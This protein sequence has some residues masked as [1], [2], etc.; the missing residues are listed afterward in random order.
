MDWMDV[1]RE[2][3]L[4]TEFGKSLKKQDLNDL[5]IVLGDKEMFKDKFLKLKGNVNIILQQ[6]KEDSEMF[7]NTEKISQEETEDYIKLL[8]KRREKAED[9]KIS[10]F[11]NEIQLTSWSIARKISNVLPNFTYGALH[12]GLNVDG[13]IVE[14][15]R[16]KAGASLVFPEIYTPSLVAH[17]LE[18]LATS[19]KKKTIWENIAKYVR[20]TLSAVTFNLSEK[21]ISM[22]QI[23]LNYF[24]QI[25]K[26]D[27][28]L[29]DDIA[30]M[31][32][33]YNRARKY[34]VLNTNCQNFVNDVLKKLNLEI[35]PKGEMK[36]FLNNLKQ[37]GESKMVFK[38]T[39]FKSRSELDQFCFKFTDNNYNDY[40]E[41]IWDCKLLISFYLVM[42]DRIENEKTE[43]KPIIDNSD[44]IWESIIKAF[45]KGEKTTMLKIFQN[46]N[47]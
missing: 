37:N 16:G 41:Y 3:L 35:K 27:A 26:I 7:K 15:G 45:A 2:K 29:L 40:D 36:I 42:K 23:L 6:L 30:S 14:W 43:N 32:V 22:S 20:T 1:I 31:C 46:F 5:C 11:L 38:N 4:K 25:G 44:K 13:T 10:L 9:L 18:I 47:N 19:E 17:F 39:E 12:A 21:L 8:Q 28:E 34:N 33:A 24:F